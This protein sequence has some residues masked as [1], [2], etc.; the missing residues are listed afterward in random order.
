MT[1]L[2]LQTFLLLLASYFAGALVACFV[3]R[4]AFGSSA[5]LPESV[6]APVQLEVPV[7]PPVMSPSPPPVRE[8]VAPRRPQPVVAPRAID[9]V[10]PKIDILRRPEPR[11]APKVLDPSRF[12][13]ALIG[14]DPNE[15]IPRRAI[16]ELR[17]S[18][19][20]PVTGIYRPKPPEPVAPTELEPPAPEPIAE[21]A[22]PSLLPEPEPVTKTERPGGLAARLRDATTAAAAGAVAAAKAAAAAS[23]MMPSAF[24][25][26]AVEE[27]KK[28]APVEAADEPAE[29]AL[30]D[31]PLE[32]PI[33]G[34]SDANVS[35]TAPPVA[36]EPESQPEPEPEPVPEPQPAPAPEIVAPP[37]AKPI[38]G[39]DDFQ[40]IRAID[41]DIEQRL[42]AAGVNYFE[43][44]AGWTQADVKRYGQELQM[45]GRIDREQW[46]EQAQILAKGGETYYSRNRL[47]SLKSSAAAAPPKST[48]DNDRGQKAEADGGNPASPPS[49]HERTDLSGVAAASQGRS[50]AEMAAAAAAAIAAAS[51]SVT[52]GLKPIE[53]I[54][55][56]SK[57]D[58]KISI[59][60]RITDAI[61]ERNGAAAPAPAVNADAKS[62]ADK[63]AEESAPPPSEADG[64]HDDLKRI[65]GIGV[66]IE[67]RLNAL[68]VG[69]YE[70]IA[71]W[72]SGDIDRISRSLEF[73]GR[74]ERENW[75]EQAR[76]LAS[77]GQT[78]FSRRVDRGEVDTSRE[79]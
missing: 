73:K 59:P 37:V 33:L 23:A 68:G 17:P 11:P 35:K 60:A 71:N 53:P 4:A 75:V 31:V 61:R 19:L 36:I 41:G 55:P 40:R 45:P 62:E 6:L 38:E 77:G 58:P 48:T 51:A 20:K 56:L 8:R 3:K 42:K 32:S 67:K 28:E 50:V 76:I 49:G 79:T 30:E 13:R 43:D 46:V 24:S 34:Y 39:G 66:L 52:R 12:L 64:S 18:V 47:A 72:T 22:P 15:G 9:P 78:E 54:S 10:Q 7:R 21:E 2:L 57:V 1:Y 25:R 74:I 63:D 70:Q 5:D 27:E 29:V 26:K 14:P 44:I 69:T 65:R 16:V